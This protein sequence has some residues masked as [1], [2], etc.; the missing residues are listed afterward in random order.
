MLNTRNPKS[1]KCSKPQAEKQHLRIFAVTCV[2]YQYFSTQKTDTQAG[3]RERNIK[4]TSY[5]KNQGL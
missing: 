5:D 1:V 3:H 4:Y 2:E